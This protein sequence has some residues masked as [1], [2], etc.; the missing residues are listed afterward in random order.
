MAV[1]HGDACYLW[2]G[3]QNLLTLKLESSHGQRCL[4]IRLRLGRGGGEHNIKRKSQAWAQSI[5]PLHL[6]PG[7]TG[8]NREDLQEKEDGQGDLG[9]QT[10]N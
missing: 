8:G 2:V 5:S 1:N 3:S 10:S 6:K 9:W 7:G 4:V